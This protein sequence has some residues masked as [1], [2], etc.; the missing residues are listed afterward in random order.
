[1]DNQAGPSC[2]DTL[3]R[4]L[5]GEQLEK[6]HQLQPVPREDP[7]AAKAEETT[8]N[9]SSTPSAA[10]SSGERAA[11]RVK[12][13]VEKLESNGVH[14]PPKAGSFDTPAV[15]NA[16]L[17]HSDNQSN[18]VSKPDAAKEGAVDSRDRVKGVAMVKPE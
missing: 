12:L 10:A 17:E 11:K 14:L 18:G 1:M 4:P 8:R 2:P 5:E 13:D 15:P 6:G 16:E 9:E 3:K 7:A